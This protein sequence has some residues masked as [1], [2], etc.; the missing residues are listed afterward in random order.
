[1]R[2]LWGL[3]GG[4]LVP[5]VPASA[6][7]VHDMP[8]GLCLLHTA[9]QWS[10]RWLAAGWLSCRWMLTNHRARPSDPAGGV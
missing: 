9:F 1:V 8:G 4:Q 3:I 10:C 7:Q 2:I 6:A 5:L